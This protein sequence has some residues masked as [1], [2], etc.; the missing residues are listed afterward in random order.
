MIR[1]NDE[2]PNRPSVQTI[3]LHDKNFYFELFRQ[4]GEDVILKL[5][6]AGT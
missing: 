2:H 1:G 6:P 5:T 4:G 3:F